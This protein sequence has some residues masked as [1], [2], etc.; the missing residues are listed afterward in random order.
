MTEA[1]KKRVFGLI[2]SC[3]QLDEDIFEEDHVLNELLSPKE[4]EWLEDYQWPDE[5]EDDE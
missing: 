3:E 1:Y 5:P 2:R 4:D